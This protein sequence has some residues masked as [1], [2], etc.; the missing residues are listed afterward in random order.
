MARLWPCDGGG[1]ERGTD[2]FRVAARP[3]YPSRAAC[4]PDPGRPLR[5]CYF[6]GLLRHTSTPPKQQLLTKEIEP[7]THQAAGSLLNQHLIYTGELERRWLTHFTDAL[8]IRLDAEYDVKLVFTARIAELAL[9]SGRGIHRTHPGL[10]GSTRL[11]GRRVD[12]YST[13]NAELALADALCVR[14]LRLTKQEA[15][16]W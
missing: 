9:P 5:G 10:S 4:G 8:S 7:T 16:L 12:G 2:Y 1:M 15:T 14:Q 6:T 11:Y 3:A 13:R